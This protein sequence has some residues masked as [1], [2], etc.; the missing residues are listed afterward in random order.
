MLLKCPLSIPDFFA[1]FYQHKEDQTLRL[2]LHDMLIDKEENEIPGFTFF[3]NAIRGYEEKLSEQPAV[4]K[5][6]IPFY[7]E[8]QSR[9]IGPDL[10]PF[11]L[12]FY[13]ED[14]SY[15][16]IGPCV[17]LSFEL[18]D[19][20]DYCIDENLSIAR[21]KYDAAENTAMLED[22][23]DR[24]YAKIFFDQEYTGF[25]A[26]SNFVPLLYKA[27]IEMETPEKTT[28]QEWRISYLES[29]EDAEFTCNDGVIESVKH[30]CLPFSAVKQIEIYPDYKENKALYTSIINL[31]K[32]VHLSP[33]RLLVGMIE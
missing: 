6:D 22:K 23:L 11:V 25:T 9:L 27:L 1:A 26:D 3:R 24:E 15:Q 14:S 30:I 7:R 33:E 21:C 29:P 8:N 16:P 20:I 4:S 5:G 2:S 19:L 28:E 13:Q 32:N 17:F 31:L 12:S 18:D 10:I